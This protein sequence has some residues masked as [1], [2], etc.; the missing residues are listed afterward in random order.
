M[1]LGDP[2]APD[3]ASSVIPTWFGPKGKDLQVFVQHRAKTMDFAADVVVFPGGRVS[4]EDFDAKDGEG[5]TDAILDRHARA[6]SR[7]SIVVSGRRRSREMC[8]VLMRCARREV[9]EETGWQL[10]LSLLVP[11]ANWVTPPDLPKRF[12]TYFFLAH[13]S[14]PDSL[15]HQTTEARSSEWRTVPSL[16]DDYQVGRVRMMR[17]TVALL[18]RLKLAGEI[19]RS[20]SHDD[21]INPERPLQARP[22]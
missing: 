14:D 1:K 17:P 19:L 6:W 21:V 20:T 18:R 4:T 22:Y 11:W 15:S 8:R 12:D 16:L 13:V 7:C 5:I 2:L 3:L 10:D 9:Q